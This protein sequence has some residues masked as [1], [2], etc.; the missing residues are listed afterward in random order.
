M[1]AIF[2]KFHKDDFVFQDT[3]SLFGRT[4]KVFVYYYKYS[5]KVKEKQILTYQNFS[6]S[7]DTVCAD[8]ESAIFDYYNQLVLDN[9]NT[10]NFVDSRD[11]IANNIYDLAKNIDPL[12]IEVYDYSE[13]NTMSIIFN[14]RWDLEKGLGVLLKNNRVAIVGTQ[15][16]V[17]R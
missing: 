2:S 17:I 11:L 10:L 1:S 16:E 9:E 14:L 13:D 15:S 5:N 3:I 8:V 7:K 6:N 4:Y 12:A